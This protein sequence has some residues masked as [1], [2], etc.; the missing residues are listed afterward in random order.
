VYKEPPVNPA[1]PEIKKLRLKLDEARFFFPPDTREFCEEIDGLAYTVLV[2]FY[3]SEK[4]PEHVQRREEA[5]ITLSKYHRDLAK[6]FERDLGLEQ[7]TRKTEI[8]LP[9]LG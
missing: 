8:G 4:R 7:L 5:K 6:R 1:D 2:A 9:E 3:L